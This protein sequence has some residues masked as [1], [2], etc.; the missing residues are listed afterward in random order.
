MFLDSLKRRFVGTGLVAVRLTKESCMSRIAIAV[1]F[2]VGVVCGPALAGEYNSKLNVGDSA[3]AWKDLQGVDGK[4]HSLSELKDKDVVVVVI[5]C[6]HCPVAVAY[7]DRIVAFAKKYAD[8]VALVAINV[9]NDDED[10]LDKMK[11]RA[12]TKGFSF[13]YLY[14]PSQNIGREYGASVTPEFFVLN[15]D[16][17]IVYMGAMDNNINPKKATKK[18][19]EAAVDATLKGEKPARSETGAQGCSILYDK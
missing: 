8:K 6:N 5:T 11:V 16:R 2:A 3:P 14:D 12:K 19:L 4:T 15:K 1:L 17:K 18:F 9:N 13:P 7:E 10:R